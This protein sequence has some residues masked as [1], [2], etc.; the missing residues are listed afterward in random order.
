MSELRSNWRQLLAAMTA[1]STGMSLYYAT[2]SLFSIGLLTEFQASRGDLANVQALL[3]V[4]AMVAPALGRAFDRFGFRRM[5]LLGTILLASAHLMMATWVSTL[6]EFAVVALIYGT[7]GL[8]SGPLGY[9]SLLTGWF[10]KDRGMALGL[11]AIGVA[12]MAFFLSPV[13]EHVIAAQGWRA[14]FWVLAALCGVIG[15][16]ATMA[17]A[18]DVERPKRTP[19]SEAPE[20]D[21]SHFREPAFWQLAFAHM[22]MAIPG[23]GL[24]SQ[25]SPLIQDEGI[26]AK[27]AALGVAAYSVGQVTGRIVAGWFLD[28]TDPRKVAIFFTAVPAI[29]LVMLSAA[30]LSL[31]AAVFAA[32]MVGIQQGAEIDLFAFFTARRFGLA[33]YGQVY[34]WITAFGWI[35]NACGILSFGWLYVASGSYAIPEAIGAILLLIG[36]GLIAAV[37]LSPAP[38]IPA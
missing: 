34:G 10:S 4:G 19:R 16:P 12:S 33:R 1:S 35:G 27:A 30:Q 28:R 38:S 5:Y 37:R 17:L 13:L 25:L 24:L 36:A 31:I 29:G 20:A 15:I 6:P 22:A 11:A 32:L 26:S 23:A 2:A 7:A 9:I 18:R 3:I 8:C 14:G 21:R